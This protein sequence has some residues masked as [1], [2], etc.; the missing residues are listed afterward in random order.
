[1][2]GVGKPVTLTWDNGAGLTFT[3]IIAVD[4]HYMFT[5]TDAVDN[6]RRARRFRCA[7]TR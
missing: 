6:I 5:I 3:R 7:P 4:D 1:M 2:L